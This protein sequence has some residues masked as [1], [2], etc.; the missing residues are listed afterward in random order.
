MHP[1]LIPQVGHIN[2]HVGI[3]GQQRH[4]RCRPLSG[5]HNAVRPGIS[6]KAQLDQQRR[7]RFPA[8]QPLFQLPEISQRFLV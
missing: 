8:V 3:I 6:L 5:H 2:A 7:Q 1:H 4:P